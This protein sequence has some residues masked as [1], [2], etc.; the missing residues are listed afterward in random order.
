MRISP[1]IILVLAIAVGI[2]GAVVVVILHSLVADVVGGVAVL[3]A[4]AAVIKST[5]RL[6]GEL[7]AP[8]DRASRPL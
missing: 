5:L 4:L 3:V 1:L 7:E 2:A 8:D 6:T